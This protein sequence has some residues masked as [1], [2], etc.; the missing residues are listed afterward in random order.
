MLHKSVRG[1]KAEAIAQELTGDVDLT[2]TK[3]NFGE[4]KAG[5]LAEQ[6]V[7]GKVTSISC[8]AVQ[9]AQVQAGRL[10]A[11]IR[12]SEELQSLVI[13]PADE[14]ALATPIAIMKKKQPMDK[15]K[16]KKRVMRGSLW[17]DEKEEEVVDET[18]ALEAIIDVA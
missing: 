6:V 13:R 2:S 3:K 16:D 8:T 14:T 18:T 9:L 1:A 5:L 10:V 7:A 11:A 4:T 17:E 12:K 15:S